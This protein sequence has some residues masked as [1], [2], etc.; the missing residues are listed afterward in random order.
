M[1]SKIK[2]FYNQKQLLKSLVKRDLS[3]KYVG[4]IMGF[5]WSILNPLIMLAIF[6][7]VFSVILKVRLGNR[8]GIANFALYLFCGMLPWIAFQETI[9]RSTNVLLE[10]ANLIKKVMFPSKILPMYITISSLINELIG[11][12]LLMLI[13]LFK[14]RFISIYILLL[15]LILFL[16]FLFTLGLGWFFSSLNVLFRDVSQ[17]ITPLLL[18]WMY[19]TPIVYPREMVPD[20]FKPLLIINPLASLVAVYRDILL[21]NKMPYW[22][23]ILMFALFALIA[24]FVGY[25]VFSKIQ[26][27]FADLL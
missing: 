8:G 6:T 11:L 26:K 24:F 14:L 7:F 22:Q 20:M 16:Q 15:P 9:A 27:K 18:V 1:I 5:F 13:V 3:A 25:K 4:S 12:A 17:L 21:R 2:H 10:H 23:D 19:L